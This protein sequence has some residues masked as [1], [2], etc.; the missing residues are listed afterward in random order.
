MTRDGK[1]INTHGH[2]FG[3]DDSE[4]FTVRAVLVNGLNHLWYDGTRTN[5]SEAHHLLAFRI[6][7]VNCSKLAT[8]I[9]EQ[10]EEVVGNTFLH[11]LEG[12]RRIMHKEVMN[13]RLRGLE[14]TA[15]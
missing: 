5:S 7:G 11:F 15:E 2:G 8:G 12:K 6:H 4:L 3:R 9:P 10:D 13:N 1:G 14:A